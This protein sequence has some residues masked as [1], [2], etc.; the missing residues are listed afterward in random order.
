[1]HSQ[2]ESGLLLIALQLPQSTLIGLKTVTATLRYLRIYISHVPRASK[3]AQGRR[4]SERRRYR[5]GRE[6]LEDT[7]KIHHTW[8]KRLYTTL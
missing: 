4:R 5:E 7:I 2:M 8:K 1:M 3:T 6:M